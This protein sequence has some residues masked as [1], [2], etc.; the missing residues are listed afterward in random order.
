M[1]NACAVAPSGIE[2]EHKKSYHTKKPN[3]CA[4][5]P[6]GIE[7][8]HKKSYHTKRQKPDL[9][10]VASDG[11]EIEKPGSSFNFLRPPSSTD[12]R[13]IIPHLLNSAGLTTFIPDEYCTMPEQLKKLDIDPNLWS[14]WA[15][16]TKERAA[17]L[18]VYKIGCVLN[19]LASLLICCP[20]VLYMYSHNEGVIENFRE[21]ALTDLNKN[22]L[23]SEGFRDAKLQTAE[24][25]IGAGEDTVTKNIEWLAIPLTDSDAAILNQTNWKYRYEKRSHPDGGG[26]LVEIPEG[27]ICP[28]G[29]CMCCCCYTYPCGLY[30]Y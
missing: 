4:V 13:L 10:S 5:A 24:A 2:M 30:Y 9:Y 8:K 11:F 3:V 21:E 18:P 16:S 27:E 26:I 6:S 19:A 22:V 15:T 29:F 14:N 7:M 12:E 17:E 25:T 20:C 28:A 23:G 1:P